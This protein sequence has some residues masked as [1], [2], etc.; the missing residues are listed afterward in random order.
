MS[1]RP[2]STSAMNAAG[3][4]MIANPTAANPRAI[5]PALETLNSGLLK[6]PSIFKGARA[7]RKLTSLGVRF[8][9]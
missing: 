6:V 8:D 2:G 1:P 9:N 3:G 5:N 4:A 7:L